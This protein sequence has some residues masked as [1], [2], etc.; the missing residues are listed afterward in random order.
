VSR[1]RFEAT[2]ARSAPSSPEWSAPYPKP[3]KPSSVYQVRAADSCITQLKAQGPYRTGNEGETRVTRTR[4]EAT[5]ARSAPS[6]PA[7]AG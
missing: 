6:S 4:F 2:D 3:L 1:T 7:S 5:D